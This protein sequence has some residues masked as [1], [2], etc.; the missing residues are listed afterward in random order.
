MLGAQVFRDTHLPSFWRDADEASALGQRHTLLYARLRLGGATLAAFGGVLSWQVGRVDAAGSIILLGF[1]VALISE[2]L[3][4][5]RQPERDWYEGRAV[6]ESVKTLAWRYAV[7]ADPFPMSLPRDEAER[8]LRER[9][10][11][12]LDHVSDRITFN[13]GDSVVTDR[14]ERLRCS[15]FDV[16]RAT[17]I[18]DRTRQQRDWYARK[19]RHNRVKAHV[20]RGGM[21]A[22]EVIAL[23]LAALR[24]FGGWQVDLAGLMAAGIAAAAAWV[25]LKQFSNLSAAYSI[26]AKELAIQTDKLR[27]VPATDWSQVVADAE[28]AISREHT[29]WLA[30]RAGRMPL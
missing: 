10:S 27:A 2:L 9:I 24:V 21:V 8:V 23:V 1:T 15:G 3:T 16:Q 12:V 13:A 18:R 26:A 17:Y 5:F 11:R 30:S 20:W 4:W 28:E 29:M 14:M 25:A 22:A 19:A 6:A 7:G